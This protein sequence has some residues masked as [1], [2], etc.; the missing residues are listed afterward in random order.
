MA[1]AAA[2]EVQ[3]IIQRENILDNV[4]NMGNVLGRLLMEHIAP[5]KF[6]GDVRG[7]GLFWAV[8]FMQN[9]DTK[10]PF[11]Q[12]T[13]FCDRVVDRALDLG[14]NILGNLGVTG[15]T[16]VDHVL[17]CPPYIVKEDDLQRMVEI[18]KRAIEEVSSRFKPLDRAVL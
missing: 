5:M 3:R 1:C 14:L 16:Y 8:E 9:P 13:A 4:N 2:V 15:E 18:L 7:R 6:V 12:G 10:E 11:P 17:M